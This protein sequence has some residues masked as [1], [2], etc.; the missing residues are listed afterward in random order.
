MYE[1]NLLEKD[2]E[3]N[4]LKNIKQ[5]L[6]HQVDEIQVVVDSFKSS[7]TFEKKR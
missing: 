6:E 3:L 4:E 1:K 2:A 5:Q 7:S